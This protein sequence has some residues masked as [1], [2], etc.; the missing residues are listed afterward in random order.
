MKFLTWASC[1]FLISTARA[2]IV[3]S[4]AQ[5]FNSITS[6]LDFVTVQS[7]ETLKPGYV[8]LG[9]FFNYAVNSLPYFDQTAQGR[10]QFNDSLLG[11]DLNVG[12]GLGPNWD[13]GA[14]FPFVISQ[15]VSS[16]NSF[17]GEFARTGSTEI[18]FNTKYRMWGDDS[19]GIAAIGHIGFNRVID[20]PYTGADPGPT[21][22]LELAADKV[23]RNIT[24]GVNV[25]YRWRSS[26]RQIANSPIQPLQDQYIYS[27]AGSYLISSVDTKLISEIYGSFPSES[28]NGDLDRSL[29]TAEWIVGVKHD[30]NTQWS[31][32]LGGGTE[33]LHGVSSPDWRVYTGLNCTFGAWE[34]VSAALEPVVG[35]KDRFRT[36]SI[37]FAFDSDTMSG[38]YAEVLTELAQLAKDTGTYNELIIEGHTDSV[39][40]AAYNEDLSMRRAQSIRK[41]LIATHKIPGHKIVAVGFGETRPI[42]DNGNYQGR[43]LNRRVEFKILR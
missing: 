28:N 23:V 17:R 20:N 40:P 22:T 43:Q 35:E 15:T 31:V 12:A 19:H 42:A 4:D 25:G 16:D 5:N 14:S 3:G 2:N 8:N 10:T 13:I 33:I 30:I 11:L 7:S 21:Y 32:H 41:Y 24:L 38:A 36:R 1:F 37:Y 6:G 9:A 39:G 29:T 34:K 18:R 27:I 26:G